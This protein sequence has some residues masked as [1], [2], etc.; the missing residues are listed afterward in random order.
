MAERSWHFPPTYA[1]G[2]GVRYDVTEP[3]A[4]LVQADPR[5]A[6]FLTTLWTVTMLTTALVAYLGVALSPSTVRLALRWGRPRLVDPTKPANSG[7]SRRRSSGTPASLG[8]NACPWCGPGGTG[9]AGRSA[10]PHRAPTSAIPCLA[11]G[12]CA[13]AGGPTWSASA[14]SKRMSSPFGSTRWRPS[15]RSH[16]ADRGQLQQHYLRFSSTKVKLEVLT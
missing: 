3:L 1:W 11:R 4:R 6:G 8:S 13:Q 14:S 2:G 10:S 9:L 5:Q 7:G 12:I 15:D 16:R